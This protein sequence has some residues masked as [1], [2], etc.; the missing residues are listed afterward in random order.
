MV[1]ASD[2]IG[3]LPR[4]TSMF[5]MLCI[6][7]KNLPLKLVFLLEVSGRSQGEAPCVRA[8]LKSDHLVTKRCPLLPWISGI[9]AGVLVGPN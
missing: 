1:F 8:D 2:R 7:N 6:M 4:D 3:H 5:T 9:A